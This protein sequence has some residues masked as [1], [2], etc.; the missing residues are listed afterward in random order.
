M[1]SRA[2]CKI[3]LGGGTS[4]RPAPSQ[5]ATGEDTRGGQN[6]SMAR[7]VHGIYRATADTGFFVPLRPKH[8]AAI[9]TT[10]LGQPLASIPAPPARSLDGLRLIQGARLTTTGKSS[11]AAQ[12]NW[13]TPA[14]KRSKRLPRGASEGFVVV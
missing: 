14:M 11:V 9:V 13:A 8:P 1:S 5:R 12:T 10:H 7:S 6:G 4:L 3:T 2:A